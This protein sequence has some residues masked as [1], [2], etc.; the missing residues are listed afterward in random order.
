MTAIT[1]LSFSRDGNKLVF[2]ANDGTVRIW[3]VGD[4]RPRPKVLYRADGPVTTAAFN[5]TDDLL[6]IAGSRTTLRVLAIDGSAKSCIQSQSPR[7]L[8]KVVFSPNGDK[9]AAVGDGR[10]VEIWTVGK[11]ATLGDVITAECESAAVDVVFDRSGR[12]LAAG[13]MEGF[14]WIWDLASKNSEPARLELHEKS[15]SGLALMPDGNLATCSADKTMALWSL[16]PSEPEVVTFVEN[17]SVL[18]SLAVSVAGQMLA[19]GDGSGGVRVLQK[20][21]S[22]WECSLHTGHQGPVM[23]VSINPITN[24]V[25][26]A[27]TRDENVFVWDPRDSDSRPTE[28]KIADRKGCLG[29]IVDFFLALFAGLLFGS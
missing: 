19:A 16:T 23:A 7:R 13:T 20:E 15:V 17:D 1:S 18:V 3:R 9:L 29:A 10:Q 6:A 27:G 5:T 12:F 25:A 28:L 24:M 11:L 14:V 2:G 8:N 22:G 26:S 4:K 21:D